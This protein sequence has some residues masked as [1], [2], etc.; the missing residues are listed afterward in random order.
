M[1]VR[2]PI[3]PFHRLGYPEYLNPLFGYM[4]YTTT[5]TSPGMSVCSCLPLRFTTSDLT[6]S[7]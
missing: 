1:S 4:L 2:S 5:T 6:H 7:L 3:T